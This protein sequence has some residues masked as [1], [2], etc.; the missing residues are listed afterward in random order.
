MP[1]LP[2]L[3]VTDAQASRITAAF[4]SVTAYKQWLKEKII[5]HV[6]DFEDREFD[7]QYMEQRATRRAQAE[8]DLNSVQ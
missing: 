7:S 3:T 1:N 4:G 5:E 8:S 2:T 6:L